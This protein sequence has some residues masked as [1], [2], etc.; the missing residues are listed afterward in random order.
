MYYPELQACEYVEIVNT[1]VHRFDLRGWRLVGADIT[2]GGG[3]IIGPGEHMVIVENKTAYQY[4]Y[5]NV[6][7][8]LG[9]Y[10]G[11]LDNEGET[12][13]LQMPLGTNDWFTIDEVTYDDEAPW[14]AVADGQG[15][16]LQLVDIF[17]DNNRPGNWRVATPAQTNELTSPGAPNPIAMTLF[18]CPE[19]WIN[20]VMPSNTSFIA[21]NEGDFDPWIELYNGETNPISLCDYSL[22]HTYDDLAIWS[23]PTDAV[24]GAGERLIVWIDGEPAETEGVTLHTDFILGSETGSVILARQHLGDHVIIDS[25]NYAHVGENASIGSYPDG[26]PHSRQ[27]FATPTPAAVNS[28]TSPLVFVMIN[29]WMPDNNSFLLDNS[30]QNYD[31]W[32]ELFNAS[33]D[34]VNLGGYFLTDDLSVTNKFAVPGGT[35]IPSLGFLMIW[36][37]GDT[38]DNGPGRDLHVNFKLKS[39]GEEIG[40]YAPDG[41]LVD[42]VVYTSQGS[43]QSDGRWP[44]GSPATFQMTLP[45]PGK[46]NSVLVITNLSD[47]TQNGYTL[48]VA[49]RSGSTYRVE[50]NATLHDTNW[51]VLDVVTADAAVLTFTDTT[52]SPNTTRFYRIAQQE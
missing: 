49:G 48:Y 41:S 3:A 37:D 40:L 23:F 10:G 4:A 25:V 31:D 32:F 13:K 16:A 28:Q 21:D 20:E 33:S 44:D 18:D 39:A 14:P 17:A 1:S 46:S 7:R 52:L 36:A 38:H 34:S 6:E 35:T 9:D 5:G 45:T 8:A 19:L 42:A 51:I 26:D 43:D 30:D 27:I 15:A 47:A 29:E 12:I 2:F 24:I 22:S 50:A 11:H